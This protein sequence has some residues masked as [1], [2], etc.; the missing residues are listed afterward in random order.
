MNFLQMYH[1]SS[2]HQGSNIRYKYLTS[3]MFTSIPCNQYPVMS[4]VTFCKIFTS[5]ICFQKQ[6]YRETFFLY[7]GNNIFVQNVCALV[8]Y[9]GD[10]HYV[11]T[12]SHQILWT[13]IFMIS[14][15]QKYM[16]RNMLKHQIYIEIEI[17]IR[18]FFNR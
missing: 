13:M 18:F 4:H 11:R 7:L 16:K 6:Y 15:S 14:I 9:T 10:S 3:I 1:H 5:Q 2:K 17:M 8:L 12:I